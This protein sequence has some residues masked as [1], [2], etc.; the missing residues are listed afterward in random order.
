MLKRNIINLVAFSTTVF[1]HKNINKLYIYFSLILVI[2]FITLFYI[3]STGNQTIEEQLKDILKI[4]FYYVGILPVVILAFM[5]FKFNNWNLLNRN[6]AINIIYKL[7]CLHLLLWAFVVIFFAIDGTARLLIANTGT[8]DY[9]L[10]L[11]DCLLITVLLFIVWQK[12]TYHSHDIGNSLKRD[13]LICSL[14]AS[15]FLL[16]INLL[17]LID[18]P[19]QVRNIYESIFLLTNFYFEFYL[20][21]LLIVFLIKRGRNAIFNHIAL[22]QIVGFI[23]LYLYLFYFKVDIDKYIFEY[24]IVFCILLL[25]CSYFGLAYNMLNIRTAIVILF[26]MFISLSLPYYTYCVQKYFN[27]S[28]VLFDDFRDLLQKC[29]QIL[30]WLAQLFVGH[31]ILQKIINAKELIQPE[32]TDGK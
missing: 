8:E 32:E 13:F 12:Y 29:V 26:L 18:N 27:Y 14:L 2:A 16:G 28:F 5:S 19:I 17:S 10:D 6:Q 3:R 23:F 30:W 1:P 31:M 7:I 20:I 21:S 22:V 25:L 9:Q 15:F 11:A 24:W 4:Y